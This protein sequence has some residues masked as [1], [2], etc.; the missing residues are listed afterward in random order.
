MPGSS[1]GTVKSLRAQAGIYQY[2][3]I[4]VCG[5]KYNYQLSFF[6]H[7]L[8]VSEHFFHLQLY[9]LLLLMLYPNQYH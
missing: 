5:N 4:N 6:L 1:Q 8:W 7:N 2:G 3:S 9:Q